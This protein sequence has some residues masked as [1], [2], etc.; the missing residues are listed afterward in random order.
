MAIEVTND[1]FQETLGAN[2]L[3]LVDFWAPWCG[4]CKAMLPR[5]EELSTKVEGKAVVAKCN[6]DESPAP[7]QQY[8]VRS[9][10]TLILFKKGQAVE[11]WVGVQEVATL[12][13]KI[14]S[15]SA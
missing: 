13:E 2:D 8:G 9:I 11:Q 5:L 15:H 1:S 6:V 7:A 3:V 4:P 10:P 12:E 14:L